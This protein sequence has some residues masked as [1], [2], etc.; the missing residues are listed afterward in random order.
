MKLWAASILALGLAG[1]VYI[2]R[3]ADP[4][5]RPDGV[6]AGDWYRLGDRLGFVAVRSDSGMNAGGAQALVAAP[7]NLA[8]D[9]L[10]P[11]KGYFVIQT[12]T[13][14]RA[15]VMTEPVRIAR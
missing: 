1:T 9:L 8:A 4:G 2:T 11:M 5:S 14:W 13:G 7:E 10:P 12:P 15:I 3:A 6:A